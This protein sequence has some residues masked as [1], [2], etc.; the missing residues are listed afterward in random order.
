[1]RGSPLRRVAVFLALGLAV[2]A[3]LLFERGRGERRREG[4]LAAVEAAAAVDDLAARLE[5]ERP[6]TWVR[7]LDPGASAGGCSLVLYQRRL[8]MLIDMNGRILHRWPQVRA[9]GRARLDRAGRLAV[10]GADNLIKEYDWEGRLR[11]FFRLP[12][13]EDLPHHDLIQLA[14][15]RYLVLAQDAGDLSDYLLEVD[16][17]GRVV[18]EWRSAE[19]SA[20]FPG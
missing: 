18:W 8:P 10:I 6:E 11:W 19:H 17:R 15:G 3:V 9:V 16:R 12:R 1:M 4:E 7:Q 13:S 20:S 14:N 5:R 2:T